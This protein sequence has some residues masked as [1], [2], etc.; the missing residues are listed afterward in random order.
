MGVVLIVMV[1]GLMGEILPAVPGMILIWVAALIYAIVDGFERVGW[2]AIVLMII[3]W[4]MACGVDMIA[5]WF[6]AKKIGVSW[7][8][9]G[10][11]IFGT[12]LGLIIFNFWGM[13]IGM[14]L[15]ALVGEYIYHRNMLK[16]L[17]AG[18]AVILGSI[19]GGVIKLAMAGLMILIF[20]IALAW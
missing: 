20:L 8:G 7:W 16:S 1:V 4:L 13:L 14:V 15:G 6:T 17:K 3:I 18:G 19:F 2:L 5:T 10:L 9:L 12:I 11:S